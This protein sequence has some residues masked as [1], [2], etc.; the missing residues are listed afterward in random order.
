MIRRL[1][2]LLF[3]LLLAAPAQAQ[4]GVVPHE[5]V[6]DTPILAAE[7]NENFTPVFANALNRTGGTMTGLLTSQQL[8][9][10]AT[11]TYSLG[12]T[13][14]RYQHLWLSGNATIAGNI[15]LAGTIADS[16]SAVAIADQLTV[17]STT[18]P[19]AQIRYD[20]SNYLE[21]TVAS[22]GATTINAAG[23]GQAVT[24]SDSVTITT[25]SIAE[26]AI[27]DGS[28]YARLAANESIT[29]SYSFASG[30]TFFT[31]TAPIISVRETDAPVDNGR[32]RWINESTQMTLQILNDAESVATDMLFF[33]R[34]G[35]T[36]TVA[37]IGAAQ[38]RVQA[39]SVGTPALAFAADTDSGIYSAV[40]GQVGF[41]ANGTSVFSYSAGVV[42]VTGDVVASDTIT[43]A[44]YTFQA[45]TFGALGSDSSGTLKYCADCTIANPCAGGGTGAIA[46]R[47]NSVWVCN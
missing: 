26:A 12:T 27:A 23:A 45:T 11:N 33:N 5:F 36:A 29:G 15:S 41:V 21:F 31:G 9:P 22:N 28:V 32:W 3:L 44:I 2:P 4:L 1:L 10:A 24:F 25:G 18:G 30:S 6:A 16:D 43:A 38:L 14:V 40:P 34:S 13:G 42:S 19:Q 39:G 20:T 7:V 46:K 35:T 37:T 8:T 47:L 17:T